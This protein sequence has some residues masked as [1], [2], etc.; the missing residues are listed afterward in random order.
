M[1]LIIDSDASKVI[2]AVRATGVVITRPMIEYTH[3]LIKNMKAIGTWDLCNAVYGF[4]G[5]TADSHK[6]NWKDLRDVDA[7]FR[8]TYSGTVTHSANGMQGNGTNGIAN[9]FLSPSTSLTANNTHLSIYFNNNIQGDIIDISSSESGR[10]REFTFT[11]GYTGFGCISDMYDVNNGRLI[12]TNT[13]Y[14]GYFISNKISNISHTVYRNSSPIGFKSAISGLILPSISVKLMAFVELGF[15]ATNF[16]N[17]RQAFTTIGA[18][19]TDTQA[20]QQSQI[21]TNAQNILNRA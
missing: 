9:T 21:V 6:W 15:N 10:T 20:Q 17:R 1:I 19:L 5:G 3:Y 16:S 8:L 2:D 7:A 13:R 4:V 12:G 11:S 18:G 14:D